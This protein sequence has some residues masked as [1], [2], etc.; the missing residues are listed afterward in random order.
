MILLLDNYDSF[1]WN[2]VHLVGRVRPGLRLGKDLLVA[3][4]DQITPQAVEEMIVPSGGRAARLTHIIISPGPCGPSQA[5]VSCDL[6]RRFAGRVP[7]LGVCLGHQCIAAAHA[8]RVVRHAPVHGKTS[9]IH[10]D[11]VGVFRGVEP[12]FTA[13]RYHSLVV[14]PRSIPAEGWAV[15]A[16]TDEPDPRGGTNRVVM[17]LRR[18][19]PEPGRAALEGV[20][21]H[22]ESYMTEAGEAMMRNFL[23]SR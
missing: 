16:W 14:D 3:R 10:H 17:G 2:L 7:I 5:G 19:W 9:T 12:A 13:M 11:G 21:F 23:N 8:M 22:P 20:Q 15:S 18:K 1:T 4:N 6:V